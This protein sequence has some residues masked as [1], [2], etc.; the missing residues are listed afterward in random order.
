MGILQA[1][2]LEWVAMHPSRGHPNPGIK[3]RSSAL[4]ANSLP[5]EPPG[6]SKN[7]KNVEWYNTWPF[8]DWLSLRVMLLGS[9]QVT[10]FA[11]G[12]LL[13]FF[14][15]FFFAFSWRIWSVIFSFWYCFLLFYHHGDSVLPVLFSGRDYVELVL[16]FLKVFHRIL[17]WNHV[18]LENYLQVVLKYKSDWKISIGIFKSSISF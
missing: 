5:S 15:F 9:I 11:N 6:K 1:R 7:K 18:G 12:I 3:P 10:I 4:Q 2:I 8:W 14:F 13:R 17:Q 16:L